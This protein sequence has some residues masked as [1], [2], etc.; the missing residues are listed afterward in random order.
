MGENTP[1]ENEWRVM[2]VI[3]QAKRPI[4]ASE[5]I[6]ALKN[7]TNI[8][9]KTI[10]VMINRLVAK[11][12]LDYTIDKQDSRVYHYFPL[13]TKEECLSVKSQRFLKNYF[14]G[15]A[16]LAMASFLKNSNISKEQLSQLEEL[17][18]DLKKKKG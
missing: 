15:D 8:S 12:V 5:V 3:W 17:V 6:E 18:R 14:S 9:S 4:T 2:E 11:G 13:K 7:I 10:R 16:T 1:S